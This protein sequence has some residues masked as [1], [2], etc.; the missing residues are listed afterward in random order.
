MVYTW[1][2]MEPLMEL[3][4]EAA[5]R[6]DRWLFIASLLVLGCFAVAT[7]RYFVRQ[8]ERLIEENNEARTDYQS[9]LRLRSFCDARNHDARII[10]EQ[11]SWRTWT[12]ENH[13]MPSFFRIE[14]EDN[15][16][17]RQESR[18]LK[19]VGYPLFKRCCQYEELS[20]MALS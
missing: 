15:S 18:R 2:A 12:D 16:F 20:R 5:Q 11:F 4:N 8:R 14:V 10:S 13:M 6:H 19:W 3:T 17:C 7:M 9:S 1:Q